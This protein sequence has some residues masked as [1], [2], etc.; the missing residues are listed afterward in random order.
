MPWNLNCPHCSRPLLVPEELAGREFACPLCG[1]FLVVPAPTA[2]PLIPS[3][4]TPP[5]IPDAAPFAAP[6]EFDFGKERPAPPERLSRAESSERIAKLARPWRAVYFGLRMASL[7]AW[8][9]VV[10]QIVTIAVVLFWP[11]ADKELAPTLTAVLQGLTAGQLLAVLLHLAAQFRCATLPSGEVRQAA[12]RSAGSAVV[13]FCA[14]T[15]GAFAPIEARLY[16]VLAA[17]AMF[18]FSAF[19]WQVFLRALASQLGAHHLGKR[20]E[21]FTWWMWIG[22]ACVVFR[23]SLPTV[24]T[25][26]AFFSTAVLMVVVVMYARLAST[27]AAMVA[28]RAPLAGEVSDVA[29]ARPAAAPEAGVLDFAAVGERPAERRKTPYDAEES[30]ERIGQLLP[31]W[32]RAWVGLN[33]AR[34][35]T[36]V[37]VLVTVRV[38]LTTFGPRSYPW[39]ADAL[40]IV[41][42]VLAVVQLL[43]VL[44]HLRGQYRCAALPEAGGMSARRSCRFVAGAAVGMLIGLILIVALPADSEDLAVSL[45]LLSLAIPL[46]VL[47]SFLSWIAFLR[48]LGDRLVAREL[49]ARVRG[50]AAWFWVAFWV[51]LLLVVLE[52]GAGDGIA[53]GR[54]CFALLA[55]VI[56]LPTLASYANLL[57]TARTAIARRAPISGTGPPP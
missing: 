22:A 39:L 4:S 41:L 49:S 55:A 46:L 29:D 6:P 38:L 19:H 20:I 57:L 1:K 47:G 32:H 10:L 5:P 7:A 37:L 34:L 44:V 2:P 18:V 33:E 26:A 56:M 53:R 43:A 9:I 51:Q 28:I 48:Q 52:F 50:F 27:T 31:E 16:T 54:S 45:S 25:C 17:T 35:A 12:R 11:P 40:P 30:E 14:A 15:S 36:L 8:A 21:M 3:K 24:L 42:I 23:S 13:A